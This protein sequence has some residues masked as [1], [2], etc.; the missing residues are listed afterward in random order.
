MV[1]FEFLCVLC[2]SV[3]QPNPTASGA[4]F[5]ERLNHESREKDERHEKK[6]S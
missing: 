6:T 4:E 2:I 3:V 5:A 1:I